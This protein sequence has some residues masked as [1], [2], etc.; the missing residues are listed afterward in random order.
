[1]RL[2][3]WL[4]LLFGSLLICTGLGLS[5]LAHRQ[6]RVNLRRSVEQQLEKG[7]RATY[8]PTDLATLRVLG[9]RIQD[10]PSWHQYRAVFVTLNGPYQSLLE[11][12]NTQALLRELGTATVDDGRPWTSSEFDPQAKKGR[13][14]D[15]NACWQALQGLLRDTGVTLFEES[16]GSLQLLLLT[17]KTGSPFLEMRTG[18]DGKLP[19]AE[20]PWVAP[21]IGAD[22][23]SV[24]K[25]NS[26]QAEEGYLRHG[27]GQVYLVRVQPFSSGGQLV[28]GRRL[29]RRFEERLERQSPGGEFRVSQAEQAWEFRGEP[30]RDALDLYLNHVEA[31]PTVGNPTQPVSNLWEFRSLRSIDAYLRSLT[32]GI[33]TLGLGALAL[34][35]LGI[36]LATQSVSTQI[37][38]LSQRMTEVGSGTLGDNLPPA[39]PLEVRQATESFN[40]MINQLRQKEMLAKMVPKQAREAIEQEQTQGG[41]VVARRIRTTILFSDIRGFTNLSERLPPHEVMKLLDIYLSKMTTVVE[42][43]GGDVNEYIGDAILADFEDKPEAPG[44]ERAVRACWQMVQAL[45][46]LRTEGLHP[47]L[48]TLRQGLGLHTG[49]LVKGEVGAAHRSKFALIGDTV[50]LAARI[51]DRSRDGKHTGIL[52]SDDSRQDVSGFEVTLFGDET[53]KGKTGLIRVWEVVRPCDAPEKSSAGDGDR[54][55]TGQG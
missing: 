51:Q 42:Q 38:R 8:E 48:Q 3:T 45:E 33:A 34:G 15:Y 27:D 9:Y 17:D 11:G 39:G 14:A 36:Y 20:D 4:L 25:K 35:L 1:M 21:E 47:E 49:E 50:N 7:A 13:N 28:L 29:D 32:Q 30:L 55:P 10:S 22:L 2:R 23:G 40:Q 44:A 5:A 18:L 6:A 54:G 12:T 31:L 53:F 19:S 46:E 41:R 16:E 24:L 37:A 52:L 43:N 26:P